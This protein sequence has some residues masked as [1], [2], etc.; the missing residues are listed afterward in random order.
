MDGWILWNPLQQCPKVCQIK[1]IMKS[2]N[3][4][5]CN[6]GPKL[7]WIYEK[8]AHNQRSWNS[9][10]S[11]TSSPPAVPCH[12]VMWWS[13]WPN[14]RDPPRFRYGVAP[15][16]GG[17]LFR[18]FQIQ[19]VWLAELNHQQWKN[20]YFLELLLWERFFDWWI[21]GFIDLV[22]RTELIWFEELHIIYQFIRCQPNP[23]DLDVFN[24]RVA[25]LS[26]ESKVNA[27]QAPQGCF[28]EVLLG[29]RGIIVK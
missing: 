12:T 29:V 14:A 27:K 4:Y 23:V 20:S 1:K 15:L 25:F 24:A 28:G 19:N 16:E 7:Q 10:L 11:F 9:F 3:S 2:L 22:N 13:W 18:W 17:G 8:L 26:A 5:W 21:D 6:L